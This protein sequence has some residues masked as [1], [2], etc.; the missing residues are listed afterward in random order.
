[1]LYFLLV[2][3][4]L[5]VEFLKEF[6][7]F[8]FVADVIWEADEVFTVENFS[9]IFDPTYIR[10]NTKANWFGAISLSFFSL[11]LYPFFAIG[12][13]FYILGAKK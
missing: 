5:G 7:V 2:M 3:L 11:L 10:Y 4:L 1:M 12:Y 13:W 8:S 9:K 6:L